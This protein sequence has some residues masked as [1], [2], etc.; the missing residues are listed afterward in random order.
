MLN[1]EGSVNIDSGIQQFFDVLVAFGMA[2]SGSIGMGI[3]IDYG[4][5]RVTGSRLH[6]GP[7]PVILHPG[8]PLVCGE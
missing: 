1:I 4:Q 6:P 7:S 5:V 8:I 3:F 2:R